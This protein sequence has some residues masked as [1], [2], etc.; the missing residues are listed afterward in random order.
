MP[1]LSLDL[2]ADQFADFTYLFPPWLV[3]APPLPVDFTG[4]SATMAWRVSPTDASPL[5]A[6]STAPS[7]AG[8]LVLGPVA[9]GPSGAVPAG[10]IQANVSRASLGAAISGITL[11]WY[12]LLIVWANGQTTDYAFGRVVLHLGSDY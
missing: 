6:V 2:E 12:D 11:A 4:A 8:S 1:L 3:G 7:A 9:M 10:A 5:L